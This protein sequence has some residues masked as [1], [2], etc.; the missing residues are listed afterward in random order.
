M[1]VNNVRDESA[2]DVH[3][4]DNFSLTISPDASNCNEGHDA[5]GS[6]CEDNE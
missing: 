2:N 3:G 1:F 6:S 5:L 4:N